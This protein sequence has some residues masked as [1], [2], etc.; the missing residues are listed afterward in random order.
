MKER[1]KDDEA[2]KKAKKFADS[3][4]G[5]AGVD[6]NWVYEYAR[7]EYETV[8]EAVRILESKA[9]SV[10]QYIGGMSGVLAIAGGFAAGKSWWLALLSI[11]SFLLAVFAFK[12]S[13]S[14]RGP[15]DT[16]SPPAGRH[17]LKFADHE[18]TPEEAKAKA[19]AW[20]SEAAAAM[21]VVTRV[22]G[23]RLKAAGRRIVW[24]LVLLLLPLVGLA[25]LPLFGR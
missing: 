22:R 7:S 25:L 13:L 17:T 1:I 19:A 24:A 5:K 6:Y 11:P 15:E 3:Y 10:A 8:A 9:D 4:E 23:E 12:A 18:K 2:Y 21:R 20:L 16:P 14:A